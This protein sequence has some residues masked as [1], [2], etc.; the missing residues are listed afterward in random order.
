[1][2]FGYIYKIEFPNGKHYIGI[3]TKSLKERRK[4]HKNALNNDKSLCLYKAIK[5]YDMTDTFELVEIDTSDSLEELCEKEIRYII[6]YNSYYINGNG[7]NMT[8]GGEGTNGYVPTEHQKRI[9]S[10][11]M[12]KYYEETPEAREQNSERIKN[13]YQ[14]HPEAKEEMS[15]I[16]KEYYKQNPEKGKEHSERMKKNFENPE[17]IEKN[18]EAQKKY[19]E[20]HPESKERMREQIIQYFKDPEARKRHSE[21]KKKHFENP[22]VKENCSKGQ[23]KRFENPEERE[24]NSER[25]KKYMEENPDARHKSSHGSHEQFDVFTLDGTFIN[26]FTYQFEAIEYLQKEYNII[27]TIKIGAV[28]KG[29]RNSSA[30]FIF[31][32]KNKV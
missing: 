32:Y 10:E 9:H 30:G 27:S 3:T 2:T 28:L 26:T 16:K 11:K 19:I 6:E 7:Y 5:K 21:I 18:R 13:Y 23:K 17:A 4:G 31:K 22:E 24:K 14:E 20:E 15:E 1:M 25:R 29:T 8:Y 12:K